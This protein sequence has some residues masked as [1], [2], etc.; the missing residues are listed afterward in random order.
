MPYYTTTVFR[1]DQKVKKD[2]LVL[3]YGLIFIK[4]SFLPIHSPLLKESW[5]VSFFALR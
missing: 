5:L 4:K 2:L 3:Q 1:L